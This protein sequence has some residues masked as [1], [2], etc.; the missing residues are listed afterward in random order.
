MQV[1]KVARHVGQGA[2][3]ILD[4]IINVLKTRAQNLGYYNNQKNLG[5]TQ[6]CWYNLEV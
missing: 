2:L 4:L 6:I 5:L 3:V 1:H